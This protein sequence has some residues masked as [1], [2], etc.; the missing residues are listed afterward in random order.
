[1]RLFGILIFTLATWSSFGQN[2]PCVSLFVNF[3]EPVPNWCDF[4]LFIDTIDNPNNIWQVGTPSKSTFDSA[5]SFPKA[6]LTDTI[7]YYPTNDTSVFVITKTAEN[8]FEFSYN[9]VLDFNYRVETDSLNDFGMIEF[10]PDNGGLWVNLLEDSVYSN[11]LDWQDHPPTLTGSSEGWKNA[12]IDLAGLFELSFGDTVQ[13]R[14]TFISDGI[15]DSLDGLMFDDIYLWEAV[16]D[17]EENHL[18]SPNS[19]VYPNPA[20]ES[21][22]V[23]FENSKNDQFEFV[24]LDAFGR[25]VYRELTTS[26]QLLVSSQQFADGIYH[27]RLIGIEPKRNMSGIVVISNR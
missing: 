27:Y 22:Q 16:L 1:M 24:L 19:K 17:V 7:D 25:E 20:N 10:S 21:F 8:G 4:E 2:Q 6:I 14:F 18:Q 11:Q 9:A 23:E 5:F 3:E 26:N 13:Y 12:K 15:A